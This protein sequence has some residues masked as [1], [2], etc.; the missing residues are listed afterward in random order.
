MLDRRPSFGG[1][2]VGVE[3]ALRRS[4]KRRIFRI[5]ATVMVLYMPK[6]L[7]E[8]LMMVGRAP[9]RLIDD[10]G[11]ESGQLALTGFRVGKREAGIVLTAEARVEAGSDHERLISVQVVMLRE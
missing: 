2:P 6:P 7:P 11:E 4:V 9:V 5:L 10:V 3:I 1:P 8:I